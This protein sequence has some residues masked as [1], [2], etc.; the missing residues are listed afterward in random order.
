MHRQ[1]MA[2]GGGNAVVAGG[3]VVMTGAC[4]VWCFCKRRRWTQGSEG[5][6][7]RWVVTPRYN[8]GV[9]VLGAGAVVSISPGSQR[10]G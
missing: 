10:A 9:C 7:R 1:T 2:V 3:L 4:L 5:R 8:R 6:G